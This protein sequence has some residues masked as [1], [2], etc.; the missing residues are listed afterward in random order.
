MGARAA[1]ALTEDNQL[2]LIKTGL[3]HGF[4]SLHVP[5]SAYISNCTIEHVAQSKEYS[6]AYD[7]ANKIVIYFNVDYPEQMYH[8]LLD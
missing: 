2:V 8:I 6:F 5:V 3:A 7:S 4:D 1:V